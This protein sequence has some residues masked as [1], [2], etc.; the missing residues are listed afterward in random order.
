[1]SANKPPEVKNSHLT[2]PT[3]PGLGFEPNEDY[4]KS[5]LVPDEPFWS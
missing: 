4:L 5:Q 2:V 3:G 1:M